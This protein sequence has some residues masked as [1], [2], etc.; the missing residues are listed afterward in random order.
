[1]TMTR[2]ELITEAKG[3]AGVEV[4]PVFLNH[5]YDWVLTHITS[6]LPLIHGQQLTG[7]L[8]VDSNYIVLPPNFS[9]P[10]LFKVDGNEIDYVEPEEWRSDY[11]ES[12]SSGGPSVWTVIK[13]DRKL[14][15]H[16]PAD[17]ADEYIFYY[18]AIHPLAGRTFTFTSG[19]TY[20]IKPGNTITGATSAKTA[21]VEFVKTTSGMWSG[22]DAAGSMIVSLQTGAFSAENLN[23]GS[24]TNEATIAAD[25]S[26]EDDF[27]HL[28]GHEFDEAI[29]LGIA[30][31]AC[32]KT[33]GKR[34][35]YLFLD[36]LYQQALDLQGLRYTV[37]FD[38]VE[39]QDI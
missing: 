18:A 20:E 34:E 1:M 30:A 33:A 25:S 31:K 7:T 28:L 8:S 23:V 32:L 13:T 29:A 38:A 22:G 14:Y 24:N 35:D 3:I 39:Y 10:E 11:D 37:R 19:G 9:F 16:V 6:K 5:Q 26:N 27:Q 4:T 17:S 21:Y 15:F 36:Q 2:L 12:D